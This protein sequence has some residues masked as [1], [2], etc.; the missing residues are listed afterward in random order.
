MWNTRNISDNGKQTHQYT[1]PPTR[2][3]N[4]ASRREWPSFISTYEISERGSFLRPV[5]SPAGR[6]ISRGPTADEVQTDALRLPAD[7]GN[8]PLFQV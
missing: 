4:H 8:L 7:V 1:L 2:P 3:L 5:F 6:G